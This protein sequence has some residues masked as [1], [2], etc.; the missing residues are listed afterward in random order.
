[1]GGLDN[2]WMARKPQIVVGAHVNDLPERRAFGKFDFDVGAL[3]RMDIPFL[4]ENA[5]SLQAFKLLLIKSAH[6]VVISHD[7]ASFD[8]L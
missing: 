2:I 5:G 3:G 4:L 6:F 1:M 7:D 8:F